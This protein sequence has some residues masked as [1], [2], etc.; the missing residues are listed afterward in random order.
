MQSYGIARDILGEMERGDYG[1]L[2]T[3]RKGSKG[4]KQE[5]DGHSM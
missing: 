5:T 2:M 4:K 3:G 1:I